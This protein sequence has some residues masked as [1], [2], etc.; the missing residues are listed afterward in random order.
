MP[1]QDSNNYQPIDKIEWVDASTLKANDYNPNWI[2]PPEMRLLK[3]SLL[4]DGW[5]T[6]VVVREDGEIVDGF[7]RVQLAINDKKIREMTGGKVPVVYLR[8]SNHA[9]QMLSTIRH[10]RA[11]GAHAI[12]GMSSFINRLIDEEKLSSEEIQKRLGM[13]D[14]EV[15]RL[16]DDRGLPKRIGRE[17]FGKGWVPEAEEP[18]QR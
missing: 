6:P 5:T 11:R 18:Q 1:G 16:Y 14:E 10:N 2:P 3:I 8:P 15:D 17:E 13:E 7:H 12:R 4:E 9:H